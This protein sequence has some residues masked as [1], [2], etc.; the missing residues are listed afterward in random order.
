MVKPITYS[1]DGEHDIHL[2]TKTKSFQKKNKS[3][4][5]YKQLNHDKLN[6]RNVFC[7]RT[8]GI[9]SYFILSLK[10]STG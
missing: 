5:S 7:V 4:A 1:S 9:A 3:A 8:D 2:L 10:Q 6:K